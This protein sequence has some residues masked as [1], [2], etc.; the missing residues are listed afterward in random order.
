MR[1]VVASVAELVA[2]L[3]G[4]KK[5]ADLLGATPQKVVNWRAAGTLPTRFHIVHS[6]HLAERGIFAPPSLWGLVEEDAA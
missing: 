3:G 1:K 5:T 2:E 6:K 4:P